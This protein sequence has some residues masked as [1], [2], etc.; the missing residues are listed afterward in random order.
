V[1]VYARRG[2]R[3]VGEH[4]YGGG[5]ALRQPFTLDSGTDLHLDLGF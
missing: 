2:R 4:L 3:N 5:S 1:K